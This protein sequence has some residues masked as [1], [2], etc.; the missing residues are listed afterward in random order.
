MHYQVFIKTNRKLAEV[1]ADI[2]SIF[3]VSSELAADE[4]DEFEIWYTYDIGL[5]S[6]T[7]G[8]NDFDDEES[9]SLSHFNYDLSIFCETEDTN[10]EKFANT[11]YQRLLEKKDYTLLL[12]KDM[13]F[14]KGTA[15]ED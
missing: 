15:V 14:I 10:G 8:E 1:A 9:L 4:E 5:G 12:T 2:A 7:L 13:E 6:V 11:V 3:N